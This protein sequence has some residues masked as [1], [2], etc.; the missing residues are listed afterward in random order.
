PAAGD[1]LDQMLRPSGAN[2]R[3]LQPLPDVTP[4]DRTTGASAVAPG[5]QQLNV[6]REGTFI[7]DRTGRLT[8]TAD[9]Q[10]YEFT[11]DADGRT[12]KDPPVVILPNLKLMAMEN[13]VS[14]SNR[15]LHFR[16]TGMVTEYRGRNYVL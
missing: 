9:G 6:V 4:A 2:A 14:G 16:I 15:D 10:Q 8:K 5:A 11:F 1:V 12:M 7:V 3:P 13:A